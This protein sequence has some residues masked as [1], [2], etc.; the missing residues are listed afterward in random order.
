MLHLARAAMRSRDDYEW[1]MDQVC[2]TFTKKGDRICDRLVKTITPRAADKLYDKFI[3]R[4]DGERLRT[5][6][7][8]VVLCRK[9][10]RVVRRL[11]PDEFP[12]ERSEPMGRRHHEDPREKEKAG[13]DARRGLHLCAWVY[14]ER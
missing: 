2:N 12:K 11:F 10:W 14:R 4:E 6:E 8:L 13:R 3:E 1:A 9:A 5:G 7:K